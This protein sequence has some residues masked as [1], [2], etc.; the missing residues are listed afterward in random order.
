MWALFVVTLLP[1][2]DD[3]KVVRYAEFESLKSCHIA[4]AKLEEEF[5][6]GEIAICE[7][8]QMPNPKPVNDNKK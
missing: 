7:R 1:Y 6:S 4:Q 5:E 2:I 3:A 8:L